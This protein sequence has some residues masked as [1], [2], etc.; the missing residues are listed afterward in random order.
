[1]SGSGKR[2]QPSERQLGIHWHPFAGLRPLREP[3]RR[4]ATIY[5]FI[6]WFEGAEESEVKAV[7]EYLARD[8]RAKVAHENLV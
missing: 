3:G 8:L 7:L 2:T 6:E 1:M 5:D 4:G